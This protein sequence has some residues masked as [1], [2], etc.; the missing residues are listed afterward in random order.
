MLYKLHNTR[1]QHAPPAGERII[2]AI[3]VRGQFTRVRSNFYSLG[4]CSVTGNCA[5]IM[6]LE[7]AR[8]L[9]FC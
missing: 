4:V 1:K 8:G 2:Q 5:S 6:K 7:S 3:G 9:S